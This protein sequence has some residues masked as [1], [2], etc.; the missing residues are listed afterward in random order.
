MIIDISVWLCCSLCGS[1]GALH[2][3]LY[4]T[5]FYREMLFYKDLLGYEDF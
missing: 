5:A 1:E 2:F 4:F 3:Y